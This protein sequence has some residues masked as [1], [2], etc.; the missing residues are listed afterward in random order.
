MT[1][2][3][4][5]IDVNCVCVWLCSNWIIYEVG[6]ILWLIYNFSGLAWSIWLSRWMWRCNHFSTNMQGFCSQFCPCLLYSHMYFPGVWKLGTCFSLGWHEICD[7]SHQNRVLKTG[8]SFQPWLAWNMWPVTSKQ[9]SENRALVSTLA[10]MKYVTH[11]IKTGFW[12]Q[13]TRF[14]L[15]WHEICDPTHQNRVLKI[16]S[17]GA[18]FL[19]PRTGIA[20]LSFAPTR[21][22]PKNSK[23]YGPDPGPTRL[24]FPRTG[25]DRNSLASTRN[26]KVS[27]RTDPK[28]WGMENILCWDQRDQIK[29]QTTMN[30]WICTSIKL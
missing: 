21:T 26:L 2:Y 19:A 9:G 20:P 24:Y 25:P 14:S 23:F 1:T 16:E 15:G 13:G 18:R 8:H 11:H 17:C 30:T 7:P 27:T 28:F 12:K 10:G 3:Y 29:F 5:L 22:G 6:S 4:I